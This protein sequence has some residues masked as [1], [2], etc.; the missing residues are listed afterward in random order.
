MH[1]PDSASSTHLWTLWL[2]CGFLASAAPPRT[3]AQGGTQGCGAEEMAPKEAP[4]LAGDS[5]SLA[6]PQTPGSLELGS[7]L[8]VPVSLQAGGIACWR[9]RPSLG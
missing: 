3:P 8:L 4:L 6:G 2:C 5:L 1:V 9:R 7:R